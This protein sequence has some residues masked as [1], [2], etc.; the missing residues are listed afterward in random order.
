MNGGFRLRHSSAA[1]SLV[2]ISIILVITG[3]ILI[4]LIRLRHV[5]S[6][7]SIAVRVAVSFLVNLKAL[8]KLFFEG[9]LRL[10]LRIR[11]WQGRQLVHQLLS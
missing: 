2:A 8:P 3:L 9:H 7:P 10:R 11:R 5:R 6:D 1:R 4:F